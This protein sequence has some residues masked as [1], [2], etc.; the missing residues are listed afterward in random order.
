MRVS[1]PAP[2]TQLARANPARS[3]RFV[4]RVRHL[5]TRAVV[6]SLHG[7][8]PVVKGGENMQLRSDGVGEGHV[9]TRSF[10][11]HSMGLL[12]VV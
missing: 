2:A 4:S 8:P 9:R 1:P 10:Q 6:A 7:T 12:S 11:S 5:M 3:A